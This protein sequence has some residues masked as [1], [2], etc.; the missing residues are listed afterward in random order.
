MAYQRTPSPHPFPQSPPH[1]F[2]RSPPHPFPQSHR[3]LRVAFTGSKGAGKSTATDHLLRTYDGVTELSV[4]GPL[5]ELIQRLLE[6]G[7]KYLYDPAHK[8][9]I[10][11]QL[12]VSGRAL[13][14]VIGTELFRTE[15]MRQL[16]TLRLRGGSIWI[17]ALLTRLRRTPGHIVV[18]DCRFLDEYTALKREGFTIVRIERAAAV[19]DER[20]MHGGSRHG[21]GW[22]WVPQCITAVIQPLTGWLRSWWGGAVPHESE[23]GCP[24]DLL[25]HN[26]GSVEKLGRAVEE[27]CA[28]LLAYT[29]GSVGALGCMGEGLSAM[30]LV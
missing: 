11:P 19:V 8:E 16:P 26:D 30:D 12:N 7:D 14:Q 15:L 28:R 29:D 21:W 5:K 23:R 22:S 4:A 25:I 17:H 6:V 1:P 24:Y 10:I 3:P 18:S 13:C 27:L 9:D 2:P 20:A